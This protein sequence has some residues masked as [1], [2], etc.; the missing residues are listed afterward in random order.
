MDTEDIEKL[1]H[2]IGRYIT[3]DPITREQIN[4]WIRD[5]EALPDQVKKLIENID[6][7]KLDLRYRP[8]GW[9]IRQVVH[10]LADSHY[11]SFMRFKLALTENNPV[12]KPYKQAEWAELPDTSEADINFSLMIL[13]GLHKRWVV[14]LKKMTPQQFELTFKHP[15]R[16]SIQRL[17][18]NLGMYAWHGKHH[19][20]HIRLALG[21]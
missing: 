12:I 15:E 7:K 3:P 18:M 10:H 16:D 21:L 19:L 11:N 17:D 2:P 4:G 14:L 8:G 13:E 1:K 9:T 5:I 20:A 6:D